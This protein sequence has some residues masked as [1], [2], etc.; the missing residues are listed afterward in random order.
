MLGLALVLSLAAC[1]PAAPSPTPA[2]ATLATAPIAPEEPATRTFPVTIEH[3]YGSTE[4]PTEPKRVLSL[5]YN[6]HDTIFA[7]GVE[8]IAVRY[9]YG[10]EDDAVFPWA[11]EAA[12]GANPPVLN[13]P[14]GELNFEAIAALDPDLI[15]GLYSGI[16]EEEYQTL[17]VI[18]PT[19]TQTDEYIDFGMPW[20]ETT[21]TIGA[22]LGRAERAEELVAEVEGLFDAARDAH[23]EWE[24]LSL[25]IAVYRPDGLR[26]FATQDLR[27]RFFTTLGFEIPAE[28]DELAGD[29]FFADLSRERSDLLDVDVLLW[30]Q[31]RFTEGGRATIEA[32]PLLQQLNVT[33]EGRAVFIGDFEDAYA[34]GTVLSLPWALEGL[35][36]MLERATR[37]TLEAAFPVTIEHKFGSTTIPAEPK[38][39]IT[40][41]FSEQ[42]PV[43]ALGVAPVAVR[44]WF[45][46]QPYAVWPWAQDE[47]GGATPEVL[48]MPFG[49]L[50]FET[51]TALKPDL[52]V[53]THS[54]ITEEEYATLSQI[55]PTLAQPGDYPD[56]GVPWQEQTRLI[57]QALGRSAGAEAAIA[58]VETRIAAAAAA[59]PEFAQAS[60]AWVMATGTASEFWVV[61]PNTP[62]LRF[63]AALGFQYPAEIAAVVGDLDSAKISGEWMD[64]LDVDVLIV[65]V[66]SLEEKAAIE[67]DP[68]FQQLAAAKDKRTIFFVG[69]A[70]PVY[71]ALSFSTVLSLPYAIDE[72]VPQLAAAVAAK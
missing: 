50:N 39:V 14:H 54:G 2:P 62:P 36:P 12:A 65:K 55:A 38:R 15:L 21:R 49:E 59:H 28:I 53:A 31:V 34:W 11:E 23:P 30:D 10:D 56:F 45:G 48:K 46:D 40:L 43:L 7:L 66:A 26:A 42:D 25:V 17:S 61:G 60:V 69:D 16:T 8:P 1:A 51:L 72:L 71:G 18:A 57:G 44:D 41:G 52:I 70:D 67:S 29:R 3:K 33:R 32:D 63:L 13:M 27:S 35:V 58:E 9:W 47:L 24:G 20:Q 5:G 64:L 68:L 6:E 19:V 22:A 4:I 37:G